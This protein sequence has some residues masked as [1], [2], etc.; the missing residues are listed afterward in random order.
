MKIDT[1]QLATLL[2]NEKPKSLKDFASIGLKL[3]HIGNGAY[4]TVYKIKDS[5]FVI[6]IPKRKSDRAHAAGEMQTINII[7]KAKRKHKVLKKYM[8]NVLYYDKYSGIIVMEQYKI[9]SYKESHAIVRCLMD[10]IDIKWSFSASA[11]DADVHSANIGFDKKGNPKFI[12][13]GYFVE[14]GRGW[15]DG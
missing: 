7:L 5:N 1:L 11:E 14:E 15:S 10:I 8:P 3:Y 2:N 9:K 4:R 13:M 12:D 6:K